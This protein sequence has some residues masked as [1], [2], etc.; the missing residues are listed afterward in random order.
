MDAILDRLEVKGRAIEGLRCKLIYKYV[1]VEPV[2]DETV[3]EGVLLFARGKPNARFLIQFN[4]MIADGVVSRHGELF[5]FDGQ[6]LTERNDKAKTVTR[7]QIARKGEHMNP[8]ELGKGPF[9]LPFGQKREE[10][11]RQFDVSLKK[12]EL[13]DPLRTRHLHCIPRPSS[14]LAERYRR[15][16]IYVDQRLDLPI[17]IVCERV[18]DDNRIE[19]DFKGIDAN[20]APA[21]SR[22][23]VGTVPE[24]YSV[25][26]EPL[27]DRP[28]IDLTPL[29]QP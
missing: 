28:R 15:V 8:F 7:R 18:S 26:E 6:W 10:I 9:P 5:L 24:D 21:G 20:E 29:G 23:T 22:F 12:F 4:K 14:A 17:R 3:K 13:G 2:E 16:E 19:V 11:L 1:T 27:E 25:T